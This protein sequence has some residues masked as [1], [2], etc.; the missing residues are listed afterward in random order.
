MDIILAE[1]KE[2]IEL[3]I[4]GYYK[5]IELKD[6]DSVK[7]YNY[8]NIYVLLNGKYIVRNRL[9]IPKRFE[10]ELLE[11]QFSNFLFPQCYAFTKTAFDFANFVFGEEFAFNPGGYLDFSVTTTAPL[12]FY[13]DNFN[14]F[15][16]ISDLIDETINST[17]EVIM[18]KLGL[19]YSCTK[20]VYFEAIDYFLNSINVEQYKTSDVIEKDPMFPFNKDIADKMFKKFGFYISEPKGWK[21]ED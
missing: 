5:I 3:Q 21:K 7:Q 12:S 17:Y 20:D 4:P 8:K 16:K 15:K 10:V 19:I 1:K 9:P 13:I 18:S 2:N 11:I 6:L 14:E